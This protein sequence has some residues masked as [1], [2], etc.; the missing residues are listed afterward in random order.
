MDNLEQTQAFSDTL[1]AA[2]DRFTQEFDLSYAS[3]I[4]VLTMK[5]IEITIQSSINYE[6]DDETSN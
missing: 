1:D 2:I 3:V 6:D 5:A 4:G